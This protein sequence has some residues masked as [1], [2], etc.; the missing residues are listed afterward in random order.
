MKQTKIKL[1][2]CFLSHHHKNGHLIKGAIAAAMDHLL[3]KITQIK[4][5]LRQARAEAV[6]LNI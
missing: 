2:L 5:I 6:D 1:F 4:V 3:S